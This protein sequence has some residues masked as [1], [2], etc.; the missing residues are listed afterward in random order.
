[1]EQNPSEAEM[2]RGVRTKSTFLL[3]LTKQV[4]TRPFC[5]KEVRWALRYQKKLV[6]VVE[7]NP[8]F[9]YYFSPPSQSISAFSS[10]G[11]VYR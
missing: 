9:G 3:F 8:E 5:Q 6:L 10:Y 2:K 1:M 4:L 11:C 7:T